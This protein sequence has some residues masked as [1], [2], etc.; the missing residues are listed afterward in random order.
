MRKISIKNV[1]CVGEYSAKRTRPISIEFVNKASA[2][3]LFENKK[4]LP[5]GLYVDREYNA[6]VEKERRILRPILRKAKQLDDFKNKSKLEGNQLV[7]KGHNYTTKNIHQLPEELSGFQSTS[8]TNSSSIG[9]FGELNVF[10]NFH[11]ATFNLH[12]VSFHS[13]EQYIQYQKA[14]VFADTSCANEIINSEDAYESK[15]LAR[16]IE[17]FDYRKWKEQA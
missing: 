2:D 1:R 9:F 8:K 6:E 16:N 3:F 17:S 13:S 11:P 15:I 10:S 14:K 4:K 5:K 12:G 7:I